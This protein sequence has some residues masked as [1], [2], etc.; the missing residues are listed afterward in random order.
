MIH[1]W[2][3]IALERKSA[4]VNKEVISPRWTTEVFESELFSTTVDMIDMSLSFSTTAVKGS[5]ISSTAIG[6]NIFITGVW[7]RHQLTRGW[8]STRLPP[9]WKET[10]GL[11]SSSLEFKAVNSWRLPFSTAVEFGSSS[12]RHRPFLHQ[13]PSS[14]VQNRN[15]ARHSS[16]MNHCVKFRN[17]ASEHSKGHCLEP[18]WRT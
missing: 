8:W 5:N 18:N 1:C 12:C 15:S 11:L 17:H 13:H 6:G 7:R 3:K 10:A 2:G 4:I 16:D 14:N 9:R